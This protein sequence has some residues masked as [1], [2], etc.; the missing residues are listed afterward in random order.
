MANWVWNSRVQTIF[1]MILKAFVP[2]S[3][4]LHCCFWAVGICFD[5]WVPMYVICICFW[6]PGESLSTKQTFSGLKLLHFW[7]VNWINSLITSSLPPISLYGIMTTGANSGFF[8]FSFLLLSFFG[9]P[10]LFCFVLLWLWL[11]N[12][13]PL[14][15]I[16]NLIFH[17]E[18]NFSSIY[19]RCLAMN[20][21]VLQRLLVSWMQY[22]LLALKGYYGSFLVVCFFIFLSSFKFLF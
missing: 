16:F 17:T 15:R 22:R 10:L 11:I 13:F 1:I 14:W 5:S 12:C 4:R 18:I 3:S 20:M 8:L 21:F 7:S 2:L 9:L 19:K 6:K